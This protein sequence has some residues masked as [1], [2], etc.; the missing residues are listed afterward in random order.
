[1]PQ[2]QTMRH[3]LDLNARAYAVQD[4]EYE[5]ALN[6]LKATPALAVTDSQAVK[7]IALLTPPDVRLTTF[8]TIY[9]AD[10]SDIVEMAKGAAALN[11][12]RD[13]DK[14]LIAEACTHHASADDIGRVK[15]PRWIQEFCNKNIEIN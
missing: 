6:S 10:K 9:A 7:K 5:E 4:T 13:G 11:D 8:S 14:I 12:L 15:L 2:I 1:M 3:I